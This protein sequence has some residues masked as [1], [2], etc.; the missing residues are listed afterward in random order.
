MRNKSKAGYTLVEMLCAVVVLILVSMLMVTGVRLG[1]E[2]YAKSV[3]SSE[4]Q[5]LCSTLKTKVSDELRYSGSLLLDTDGTP[6]G[7][8][9]QTYTNKENPNELPCFSQDE[10]GHVLLGGN[11]FL[12]NKSYPYKLQAAVTLESYDKDTRIFHVRIKITRAGAMLAET[13]FDVQQLNA[14]AKYYYTDGSSSSAGG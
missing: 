1:V 10:D 3:A 13:E 4:A 11:K 7:F 12:P 9:S 8:F 6:K 5:V 14:P 2:S